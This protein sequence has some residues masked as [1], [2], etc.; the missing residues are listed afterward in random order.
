MDEIHCRLMDHFVYALSQWETTL[1][2]NVVFHWLGTST[3]WSL[4]LTNGKQNPAHYSLDV[5]WEFSS[6]AVGIGFIYASRPAASA[7]SMFTYTAAYCTLLLRWTLWCLEKPTKDQEYS[8]W[9]TSVK[10]RFLIN[11]YCWHQVSLFKWEAIT[12][13]DVD[14]LPGNN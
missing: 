12:K 9:K 4:H 14:I 7:T 11:V 8:S 3:K 13:I 1:L 5:L 10:S 6:D 2:C